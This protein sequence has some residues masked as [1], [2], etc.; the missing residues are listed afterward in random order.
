MM[1]G[2]VPLV[3]IDL[4]AFAADGGITLDDSADQSGENWVWDSSTHTLSLY[5]AYINPTTTYHAFK[6]TGTSTLKINQIGY[7]L[8]DNGYIEADKIE[9]VGSGILDIQNWDTSGDRQMFN[10][11]ELTLSNGYITS[12]GGSSVAATK[13]AYYAGSANADKITVSNCVLDIPSTTI[14]AQTTSSTPAFIMNSGYVRCDTLETKVGTNSETARINGGYLEVNTIKGA[15]NTAASEYAYINLYYDYTGSAVIKAETLGTN[16]SFCPMDVSDSALGH[17]ILIYKNNNSGLS[18][19]GMFVDAEEVTTDSNGYTIRKRSASNSRYIPAGGTLPSAFSSNKAYYFASDAEI[20]KTV[21]LSNIPEG[22][23]VVCNG[24]LTLSDITVMGAGTAAGSCSATVYANEIVSANA[25]VNNIE[26]CVVG[27]KA[28][29]ENTDIGTTGRLYLTD[30][31]TLNSDTTINN[32]GGAVTIYSKTTSNSNILNCNSK[33]L[34]VWGNLSIKKDDGNTNTIFNSTEKN[35]KVSGEGQ[36]AAVGSYSTESN[37][38]FAALDGNP[39]GTIVNY[40]ITNARYVYTADRIYDKMDCNTSYEKPNV[41]YIGNEFAAQLLAL[42]ESDDIICKKVYEDSADFKFL[43]SH[44]INNIDD[45]TVTILS[46]SVSGVDVTS[47]FNIVK[48]VDEADQTQINLTITLNNDVGV[49]DFTVK[50][51]L[52]DLEATSTLKATNINTALDFTKTA[53]NAWSFFGDFA[54]TNTE[55]KATND[56]WAWYPNGAEG[57]TGKV[58]VLNGLNI[59]TIAANAIIVPADTTIVVKG[60]NDIHSKNTAIYCNGNVKIVGVGSSPWLKAYSDESVPKYY[61]AIQSS[62]DL[63][64][65]DIALYPTMNGCNND[66][67]GYGTS[68]YTNQQK[69]YGIYGNNVYLVDVNG[70]CTAG[71][72]LDNNSINN[73]SA[74]ICAG[75]TLFIDEGCDLTLKAFTYALKSTTLKSAEV[76]HLMSIYNSDKT[77]SYSMSDINNAIGANNVVS[78]ITNIYIYSHSNPATYNTKSINAT[79]TIAENDK[80]MGDD[81]TYTVENGTAVYTSSTTDPDTVK[82]AK[83]ADLKLEFNAKEGCYIKT[84]TVDGTN[85]VEDGYK[86][87]NYLEGYVFNE[88]TQTMIG[89]DVLLENIQDNVQIDV[90][91]KALPTCTV[92]LAPTQNG[93]VSFSPSVEDGVAAD[94]TVTATATP[95]SG[96]RLGTVKINGTPI[97]PRGNTFSFTVYSDT[98]VNVTFIRASSSGN[99]GSQINGTDQ[100]PALDG[101][102]Y[103]YNRMAEVLTT[104]EIGSTATI[105]VNGSYN[106]PEAVIKAIAERKI[107]A[108]I[109]SDGTVSRYI[110]GADISTAKSVDADV[111]RTYALDTD[112]LNGNEAMQLMLFSFDVPSD[113][114]I[115]LNAKNAGLFANLYKYTNGEFE[116]ADCAIIAKDGKAVFDGFTTSGTYAVMLS[117][118][119]GLS[120]DMNNDGKLTAADAT[121]I[122][123]YVVGLSDNG[124]HNLLAADFDGNG[125]INARDALT[126]LKRVVGLI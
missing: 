44:D 51:K 74:A 4:T 7:N 54:G 84:L 46:S 106:I 103:N 99:G 10:T 122:L 14:T 32:N 123:K 70:S 40:A 43:C 110:D 24:K 95:D 66:T 48:S 37:T 87:G 82:V 53:E 112:E 121:A 67:D 38:I 80:A 111:R 3:D 28:T 13:L 17:A 116:F 115:T 68:Q 12:S 55:C 125:K 11:K 113:L 61:A 118:Y 100:L 9:V 18:Y 47:N 101:T 90:E 26:G 2:F 50:V 96:Y 105:E 33:T 23:T 59:E 81:I 16:A 52:G 124:K 89:A 88:T 34:N 94:T 98:T 1:I 109:I 63:T 64:I 78:G 45:V 85:Y 79:V 57:Y 77:T 56:M 120:G 5:N 36:L 6:Y 104:Y 91:Y 114:I 93:T 71:E 76:V 102:G 73:N 15:Y 92:T 20:A 22:T 108:T 62:G 58:L 39:Y 83:G 60:H 8:I 72:A 75:N 86:V 65:K 30:S 126:I 21:Y 42:T 35:I 119:S 25:S 49:L 29:L 41:I 31:L 27:S 19:G 107:K 69:S 97:T 117:E